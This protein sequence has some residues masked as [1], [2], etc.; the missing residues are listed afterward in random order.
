MII[1]FKKALRKDRKNVIVMNELFFVTNELFFGRLIP[2]IKKT[3]SKLNK[4]M[5]PPPPSDVTEFSL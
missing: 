2:Q 3:E 1:K 5:V 4:R